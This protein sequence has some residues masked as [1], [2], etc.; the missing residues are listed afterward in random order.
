VKVV[1][2]EAVRMSDGASCFTLWGRRRK[3]PE[4]TRWYELQSRDG[5]RTESEPNEPN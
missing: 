3:M 4:L 5:I 1:T 2:E